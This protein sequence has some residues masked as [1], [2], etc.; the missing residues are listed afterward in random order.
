MNAMRY[1]IEK[2]LL[3]YVPYSSSLVATV[4]KCAYL[5]RLKGVAYLETTDI[6]IKKYLF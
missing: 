2:L 6:Q 3:E 4:L 1:A 5:Y